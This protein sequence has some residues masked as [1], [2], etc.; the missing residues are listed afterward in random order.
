MSNVSLIARGISEVREGSSIVEG[1][2]AHIAEGVFEGWNSPLRW[3]YGSGDDEVSG[4]FNLGDFYSPVRGPDGKEDTKAKSAKWV[5]LAEN[6]GI[7][8]VLE[9]ADKMAFQRGFT[10][11]AAV[12][13]GVP[14]SFETV[15]VKRK[16]KPSPA[17]AAV[18]PAEVAFTMR[19]KEGKPTA[20]AEAA[21]EAQ[22]SN[23]TLFNQPVPNEGELLSMVSV[24]PVK[25]VGGRHQLFGKVP[26]SSRLADIVRPIVSERGLMPAI[27][28]RQANKTDKGQQFGEALDFI[29]QCLDMLASTD[30][31]EFAPCDTI[32]SKMRSVAE[33]IAAY[34]TNN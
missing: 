32:E 22:R 31:S 2:I 14:V 17:R 13:A 30:E 25:C 8:G 29:V 10:L 33:R 12:V 16:G 27:K 5:A 28:P 6:Y 15:T 24:L 19:D 21:M 26:S 1:G 11:A 4:V 34:F 9:S 7:E 3:S 20:I 18:V 23:L